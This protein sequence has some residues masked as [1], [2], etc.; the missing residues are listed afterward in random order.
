MKRYRVV[1]EMRDGSRVDHG[2]YQNV[3]V[4][5]GAAK[6]LLSLNPEVVRVSFCCVG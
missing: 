4:A 2:E 1:A 3:Y 5:D 6:M